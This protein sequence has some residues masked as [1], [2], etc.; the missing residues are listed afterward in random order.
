LAGFVIGYFPAFGE[1]VAGTERLAQLGQKPPPPPQI[2]LEDRLEFQGVE[3][4]S[5]G[6][7]VVK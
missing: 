4:V 3:R 6:D 1:V 2:A 7:S 5:H